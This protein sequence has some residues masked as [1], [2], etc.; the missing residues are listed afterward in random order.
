MLEW[1][2]SILMSSIALAMT[3]SSPVACREAVSCSLVKC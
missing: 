3:S 2:D 1:R